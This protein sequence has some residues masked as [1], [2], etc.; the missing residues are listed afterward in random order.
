MRT[1]TGEAL[2][3]PTKQ[4]AL[5]L[6]HMAETGFIRPWRVVQRV[7]RGSNLGSAQVR[8]RLWQALQARGLVRRVQ[9]AGAPLRWHWGRGRPRDLIELTAD[10]RQWYRLQTQ[11]EPRPSELEWI[12]RQHVSPRHALAILEARDHLRHMG[13]PTDDEPPP[14]P[15]SVTDPLGPRSEPDLLTYYRDRVF[16]VEVQRDVGHRYLL[17]W[18][19]SLDLYQRL[20][21]ITFSEASLRRQGADLMLAR[22]R[23]QLPTGLVL[24]ASLERFEK[25]LRTFSSL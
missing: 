9:V 6:Q 23:G 14:C 8:R 4:G 17:K 11:R 1:H 22:R 3:F 10:G 7:Q 18:D 25:G 2:L 24:L 19:K 16:P 13:I 20:M 15:R 12:R 21:L 5:L